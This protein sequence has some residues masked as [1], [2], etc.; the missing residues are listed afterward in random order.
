MSKT[1]YKLINPIVKSILRSPLH[2]LMS[3]NTILLEF[4]GRKSGKTYTTPVSYHEVNG[5][6]RCFTEREN[7]W[8]RNLEQGEHVRLTLRGR[9]CV[10]SPRVRADDSPEL[11]AALRDF[12][13]ATPRDASHAGV[14]FGPDGE[15]N[16]SD[17][18]A[19]IQNLVLI[20]IELVGDS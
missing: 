10:G 1:L 2:G 12:L 15:P 5:S 4:T 9:D 17:I 13:I 8:W 14:A 3:R 7:R 16:A 20:T 6:L 19:A 11:G 18:D